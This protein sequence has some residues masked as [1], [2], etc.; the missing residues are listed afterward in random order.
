MLFISV[1][2][3]LRRVNIYI[4]IYDFFKKQKLQNSL[5]LN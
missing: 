3:F 5:I 4:I 2:D 1:F